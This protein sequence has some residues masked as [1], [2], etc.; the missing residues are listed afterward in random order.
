[1]P[2][3]QSAEPDGRGGSCLLYVF[4]ERRIETHLAERCHLSGSEILLLLLVRC[5]LEWVQGS[6]LSAWSHSRLSRRFRLFRRN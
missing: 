2:W 5:V 1:M 3:K 6:W 4:D